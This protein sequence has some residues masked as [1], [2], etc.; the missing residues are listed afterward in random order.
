MSDSVAFMIAD[1]AR[2]FRRALN[3]RARDLGVTGQQWRVLGVVFR[4]PGIN[5]GA[6]AEL[7]ECEP[8]TLSRMV[9]RLQDAQ[10]IERR[11]DPADRRAWRLHLTE[12]AVPL[13]DRIRDIANEICDTALEG[14]SED[15]RASFTT[16]AQRFRANLTRKDDDDDRSAEPRYLRAS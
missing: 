11:A 2:L 5:Q 15:E 10:L 3:A 1:S 13:V 8:I 4:N 16:L 6:A 9:D 12:A 7:L 14:M